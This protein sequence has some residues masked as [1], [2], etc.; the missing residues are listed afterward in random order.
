MIRRSPRVRSFCR[1]PPWVS[2]PVAQTVDITPFNTTLV[3]AGEDQ[4][5]LI[6]Q[7]NEITRHISETVKYQKE[8]ETIRKRLVF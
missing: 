8:S 7:I 2:C 3:P 4:A 1:E 5:P 6:E